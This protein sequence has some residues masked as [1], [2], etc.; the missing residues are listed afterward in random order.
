QRSGYN[1]AMPYT[2]FTH[3]ADHTAP[4]NVVASASTYTF[5]WTTISNYAI[6]A[7]S[8]NP[9]QTAPLLTSPSKQ[10][11]P[12]INQ[13]PV[14]VSGGHFDAGDYSKYTWDMA[15]LVHVLTFSAD[16]LPGVGAMD[17]LGIPESGDGIS[18]VL[19]EAKWEADALAKMQ[20][21]D[22]G[23]YYVC[24]PQNS[25]YEG[26][27][28]PENGSPQVVWPKNTAATASAVAALAQISSSPAFK[29]A[30]PQAANNYMVKAK[31]GWQFLTNAIAKYGKTGAYQKMMHFGDDFTDQDDEAWAACE[32]YLATGDQQYQTTLKSWFPDPT[33]TATFRWG[34]WKM[35]GSW[36][37]AVRDYAFAVKSGRL[38]QN[39]IDAAYMA[40][41]INTITNCANDQLKF[42]QENAYGSSFPDQTKAVRGAGWYYSPEQAF[43]IAVGYQFNADPKYLDA[44][45]RNINFEGGCNPVNVT[46]V[47]GLGT[48]R[49]REVVDQYSANDRHSLSKSGIPIGNIEGG[50]VWTGT[51]ASALEAMDFPS[52][53]ASSAPYPYYD[54]WGDSW[55]VTTEAST[56]DTVKNFAT[57]AALAAMTSTKTQAW[58]YANGNINVA[59][60]PSQG[61]PLTVSLSVPGMDLNGAR[62]VWEAQGAEP[63]Y[64]SSF[65]FTPTNYGSAWI[66]AE[67][68]WPDGRRVF[69]VTNFF[70]GNS[71]PTITVAAANPNAQ[72]GTTNYGVFTFSSTSAALTVN[73]ELAGSAVKWDDYRRPEGDMPQTVTIP[74][75]AS[76]VSMNIKGIGNETSANPETVLL[77]LSANQAYN[78]GSPYFTTMNVTTAYIP[79][80]N[81]PSGG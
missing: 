35:F 58:T 13:G 40:K 36:G 81:A 51:Y 65:T 41:C 4:A 25:E 49:Q 80:T 69:A 59:G 16:S 66:E 26:G 57:A 6:Q 53:D 22:G 48:K 39:Q 31:L 75:G 52:D 55:N 46:Y 33:S 50:F 5:T 72:I 23:F 8:D 73:F 12:F 76:S 60:T 44:M 78:L 14:D 1:V 54:R 32:M 20:D 29:A 79:V 42:S 2:R 28:L 43:D 62:I 71:L 68:Q 15:Q 37:N 18:D 21:S 19:Q 47:T 7:N 27:A 74:A 34:W 64:G 17:N 24:Y 3:A 30:Y 10:L 63:S 9:A 38:Q 45:V 77:T 11:Y 56:D 70:A 67:A 61:Q